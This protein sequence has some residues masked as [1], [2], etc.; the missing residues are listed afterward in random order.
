MA[1]YDLHNLVLNDNTYKVIP[2]GSYRFRVLSTEE[3]YYTGNSD[4]IPNGTQQVIATL[5][6][7]FTNEEGN[8]DTAVVK[9]TFNIYAKVLFSLRN[10]AEAIR[11]CE[12]KGKFMFNI[13]DCK[14]RSGV[15]EIETRTGNNGNSFNSVKGFYPP[16]K[17]PKV[18]V[19]DREWKA[20]AAPAPVAA[21]NDD[22]ELPW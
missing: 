6:I 9:N 21:A 12:E 20:Y 11:M 14:G 16:S 17:A 15:C 3:G 8:P 19:N 13:D 1:N 2:D 22:T 7:P 10:F 5:E 4:K 18:C